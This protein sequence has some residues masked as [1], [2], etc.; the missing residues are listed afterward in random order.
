[1]EVPS[2]REIEWLRRYET[3][4]H[5]LVDDFYVPALSKSVQY[6][7]KAG[8][9]SSSALVAAAT[10]VVH[11]ARRGGR[12]RLL[13][14]VRLSEEDTEAIAK[15]YRMREEVIEAALQRQ[16]VLT[17]NQIARDRLAVLAEMVARGLLE[18]R[19]VAPTDELH[20]PLTGAEGEGM[21][22]EKAGIFTDEA[23]DQVVFVGSVN[24]SETAWRHNIELIHVY[25]SWREDAAHAQAQVEDFERLWNGEHPRAL[26]LPFPDALQ[27]GLLEYRRDELPEFDPVEKAA[28]EAQETERER[29]RWLV[30]FLR[31]APL[32]ES[33]E[34]LVESFAAVRPWPHQR[35]VYRRVCQ[36]YPHHWHMLCDEVGLGKTIEA[37]FVLRSLLLTGRVRRVLILTPKHL[38]KQ[39]QEE[40]R[41]KFNLW[42]YWYD[43]VD[44][45]SP[46]GERSPTAAN[47]WDADHPLLIASAHLAKRSERMEVLLSARPWDLVVVDEA[48]HARRTWGP[49]PDHRPNRMLRLLQAL[50]ERAKAMLLLTATPMQLDVRELWDLLRLV[51][52]KG[53][54]ASN[55]GEEFRRYFLALC[56]GVPD[57]ADLAFLLEMQREYFATGGT[58]DPNL[59]A[60]MKAGGGFVVWG[61]LTSAHAPADPARI[62]EALKKPS[63]G[64]VVAQAFR[65]H[66]P[67]KQ[68]V[69]RYTRETLRRY[70]AE[71]LLQA[72]ISER[73]VEDRFLGLGP[74]KRLYEEIEAYI[75][76]HYCK[77]QEERRHG[78]GYIMTVYRQRLTSSPWAISETLRRHKEKLEVSLAS[79]EEEI[80]EELAAEEPDADLEEDVFE[81]GISLS[82]VDTGEILDEIRQ[83]QEFIEELSHLGPDPKLNQLLQDL[84][85]M[86]AEH[87][88]AVVF[89]QYKD[90][91][92]FVA[93]ALVQVFGSQVACYS[94]DGGEVWSPD[95]GWLSTAKDD[96][97]DGFCAGRY[98][99]LVCT[100]AAS[101][102]IN[103]Q[104][105]DLLINYDMHWNP[106][107]VEQRIGRIDRIGQQSKTVHVLNYY[108]A[109]S[110][111]AKI[112]AVLRERL[113]LFEVAIGPI[114]PVLGTV[115][116]RI[117]RAAMAPS[118]EKTAVLDKE[119]REIEDAAKQLAI[120]ID[121]LARADPPTIVESFAPCSPEDVRDILLGCP[122]V[123]ARWKFEQREPGVWVLRRQGETDSPQFATTVTFRQD[124]LEARPEAVQHCLAWGDPLFAELLADIPA[125]V[126]NTW[127]ALERHQT[128]EGQVEY[129]FG[130]DTSSPITNISKLRQRLQL[131]H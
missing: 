111:E 4:I 85:Q 86:R 9:F 27:R 44:Y 13:V 128:S 58:P 113:R 25:C 7:R 84:Q 79:G 1:M 38:I 114:Q 131:L 75:S 43:G 121:N 30:Q 90:T 107:R 69:F 88:R 94:G 82:G 6:D 95:R 80:T 39:W 124:V 76:K 119:K 129:V 98:W 89:T 74:M 96:I 56:E 87:P 50:R 26:T 2:L 62:A 45:V 115:A 120:N 10:G 102:G 15:G 65:T 53:R 57:I 42:A 35:E 106:M 108:Y 61:S 46:I 33:G 126:A 28:E 71:G 130:D 93:D 73:K 104:A 20:N 41:E 66:T 118:D 29:W 52:M 92:R 112:Y 14:G 77:A 116:K 63:L 123:S 117:E 67:V 103:L 127:G 22:H 11:L 64:P 3:G 48:H 70:V 55:E 24:E 19:V 60:R 100:E 105:S 97:K 49:G 31:D 54:W 23:G 78:L 34:A 51:G 18:V 68:F 47:P 109:E 72:N 12:M 101:E 59:E 5:D 122:E 81:Q 40:L 110:V 32:L 37:G 21:F 8:F 16:W 83:V 91:M 125:P 99:I 17:E 36:D